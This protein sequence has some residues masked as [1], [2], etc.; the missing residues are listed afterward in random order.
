[1]FIISKVSYVHDS[2]IL[3]VHTN[4]SN[5]ASYKYKFETELID[6]DTSKFYYEQL[7]IVCYLL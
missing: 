5:L 2:V 6:L 7:F 3:I 4:S 1:M